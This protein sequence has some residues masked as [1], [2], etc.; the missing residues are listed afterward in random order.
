[1]CQTAN[2]DNDKNN[3]NNYYQIPQ[4]HRITSYPITERHHSH[5]SLN[6]TQHKTQITTAKKNKKRREDN[7]DNTKTTKTLPRK[8]SVEF[9][10]AVKGEEIPKELKQ[11]VKCQSVE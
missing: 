1:M 4:H 5:D 2:N 11:K 10:N 3:N 7:E 8:L 9:Y 6:Y